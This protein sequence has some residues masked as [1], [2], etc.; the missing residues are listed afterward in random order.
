[1]PSF[2]PMP[3]IMASPK[4]DIGMAS[5]ASK[6]ASCMQ[7]SLVIQSARQQDGGSVLLTGK[8]VTFHYQECALSNQ[9]VSSIAM[10]HLQK[11]Q[12]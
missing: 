2:Q 3:R 1:M 12:Y 10:W 8:Y 7:K 6:L 4:D 9:Q 5:Y 11:R